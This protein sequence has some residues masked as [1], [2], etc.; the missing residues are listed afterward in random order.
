[1]S[2]VFTE[3]GHCG[4]E[5]KIAYDISR[6]LSYLH[7]TSQADTILAEGFDIEAPRRSDP[8]DL[9]WGIYL[10]DEPSRARAYGEVLRVEIET[11]RFARIKSPYFLDGFKEI[12]PTTDE[13]KLFYGLAFKDGSMLSVTADSED[14]VAVAKRIR[15][16]FLAAGFDGIL[17]G[18]DR[19]LQVEVV[20]FNPE[21]IRKVARRLGPAPE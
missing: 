9:G 11:I 6:P 18:P 3:V 1:M 4:L 5:M 21:T 14:R 12:E 8:G 19:N 10:T 2:H 20:V 16:G 15:E 7:G 13:E 17:A